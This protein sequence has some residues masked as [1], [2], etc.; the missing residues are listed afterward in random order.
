[1]FLNSE[2]APYAHLVKSVH[3]FAGVYVWEYIT[4]LDF[5]WEIYTGRRHC[6]WS[7]VIYLLARMLALAS[8]I[9]MLVGFDITTPYDCNVW[10]RI[11]LATSWASGVFASLLLVLRG[12][13]LWR[14]SKKI[15]ALAVVVWLANLGGSIYATT[16]GH[17]RWSDTTQNC[18]IDGTSDF[19]WSILIN[20]IQDLTLLCIMFSGVLNNRNSTRLWNMLYIQ[21][22]WWILAWIVTELPSIALSFRGVNEY[23]NLIFQV[24]H[25]TLTVITASRAYRIL[26]QFI[27]NDLETYPPP[28]RRRRRNTPRIIYNGQDVQVTVHRTVECDVQLPLPFS[29]ELGLP[30]PTHKGNTRRAAI[31]LK[32]VSHASSSR[33][34]TVESNS[35]FEGT[36]SVAM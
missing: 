22:L 6:R 5:E 2:P 16:R 1:M 14:R 30:P 10:F 26:F 18:P 33:S 29:S 8:F 36:G 20:F 19:R 25:M 28:R 23:W 17:S 15:I 34:S 31:A 35:G 3:V 4:N 24:P 13:A 9:T 32:D 12:V 27:T 11:M 7:F 21:G